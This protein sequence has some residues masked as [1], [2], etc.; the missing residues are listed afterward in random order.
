MAMGRNKGNPPL[1]DGDDSFLSLTEGID[2]FLI[3]HRWS[4]AYMKFRH[5]WGI[6]AV[7]FL[8]RFFFLVERKGKCIQASD[9]E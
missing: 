1:T 9:S 5:V 2:F 3:Q 6:V 7:D 4:C 8:G